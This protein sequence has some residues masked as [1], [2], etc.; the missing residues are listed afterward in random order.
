MSKPLIYVCSPY[1]AESEAGRIY[2]VNRALQMSETIA[3]LG[4]YPVVPHSMYH[5]LYG[6][7]PES[8][9]YGA[10]LALMFRCDAM[11][12]DER[13]AKS[14]GCVDEVKHFKGPCFENIEVMEAWIERKIGI[15]YGT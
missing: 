11:Y 7:Y 8:F 12:L 13:W 1:S 5:G 14:I 6:K 2:N 15:L 9:F 3:D 4:G 10:T